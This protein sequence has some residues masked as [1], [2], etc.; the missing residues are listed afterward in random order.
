[1]GN[2]NGVIKQKTNVVD[3]LIKR[4]KKKH[5]TAYS[6]YASWHL[7]IKNKKQNRNKETE[8]NIDYAHYTNFEEQIWPVM[9]LVNLI[10]VSF[11]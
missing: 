3:F 5:D 2:G 4:N 1:M 7:K 9:N 6:L 10:P 8:K 11:K